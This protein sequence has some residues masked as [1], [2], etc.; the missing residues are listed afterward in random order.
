MKPASLAALI[1]ARLHRCLGPKPR[2]IVNLIDE[3][4]KM[5]IDQLQWLFEEE[6][7]PET[8]TEELWVQCGEGDCPVIHLA[9][10]MHVGERGQ[11]VCGAC[12]E[13][14]E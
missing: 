5:T 1:S 3:T 11:P 14:R 4:V 10:S 8:L 12:W 9:G 6:L 13:E 7:D 2:A